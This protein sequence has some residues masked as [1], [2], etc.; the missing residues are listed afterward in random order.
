[1]SSFFMKLIAVMA[2]TIDHFARIVGQTG[3]MKLFPDLPLSTSYWIINAMKGIGRIAFPLFAFMIAEGVSKTRSTIKYIGRL[4]LFAIISEPFFY[5]GFNI[6]NASV[7]GFLDSLQK[8]NLTNV[9]FTLTLG[10]IAIWIY[11]LLEQKKSKK[12]LFLFVP[13]LLMILLIGGYIGC[14]YGIAGIILIVAL[15][16]AKTKS[17]KSIVILVWSIGLY[18]ISQGMGDWS[19]VWTF[20]I[21]NCVCAALSSVLIWFYNGKRGKPVKWSFYIYYPA[22]ILILACLSN[23]ISGT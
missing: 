21:L 18:I 15:Y 2:M 16:I 20:P 23:I 19:Q 17:Q 12:L 22:H 4:A 6:Q 9:F 8:L 10:A 5:Y 11:Q 14:D 13:V 3:L 1:M 7:G